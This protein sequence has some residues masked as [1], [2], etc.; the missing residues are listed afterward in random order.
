MPF[1]DD[2]TKDVLHPKKTDGEG[3][4]VPF[5]WL[6]FV[7]PCLVSAH[8]LSTMSLAMVIHSDHK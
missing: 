1:N 6:L 3:G 5:D 2:C 7:W 8:S 4:V